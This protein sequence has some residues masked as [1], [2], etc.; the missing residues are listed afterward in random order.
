MASVVFS[1]SKQTNGSRERPVANRN[2]PLLRKGAKVR[3]GNS[4]RRAELTSPTAVA[5]GPPGEVHVPTPGARTR[6]HGHT[7]AAANRAPGPPR[8]PALPSAAQA[9]PRRPPARPPRAHF[10]SGQIQSP[11]LTRKFLVDISDPQSPAE[12]RRRR[13]AGGRGPGPCAGRAARGACAPRPQRAGLAPGGISVRQRLGRLSPAARRGCGERAPPA[14]R[15]AA[16]SSSRA[17][18]PREP[19]SAGAGSGG[20][21]PRQLGSS[22]PQPQSSGLSAGRGA[23]IA[24]RCRCASAGPSAAASLVPGAAVALSNVTTS[25]E[26]AGTV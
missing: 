12:R 18:G 15:R 10:L 5:A 6:A 19:S 11:S 25:H 13:R 17:R 16:C 21:R 23:R 2:G 22:A 14:A 3:E 9:A 24:A 7:S 1:G 26:N 8:A 4:A 20:G